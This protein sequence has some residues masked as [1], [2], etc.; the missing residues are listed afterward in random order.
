MSHRKVLEVLGLGCP[1]CKETFR[2]VQHVVEREGFPFEVVKNESLERLVELGVVLTPAVA[3]E[4]KVLVAGRIPRAEELRELLR[5][6]L[7]D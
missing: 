3:L 7:Q 4:G 5:Q 1:R 6:K 2:V